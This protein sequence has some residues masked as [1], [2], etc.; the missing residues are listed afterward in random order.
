MKDYQPTI[1]DVLDLL[2]IAAHRVTW[3]SLGL[4]L[5]LKPTDLH[6]CPLC[7]LANEIMG[8]EYRSSYGE[9]ACALDIDLTLARVVADAADNVSVPGDPWGN[10]QRKKLRADL[11]RI[12]KAA[13]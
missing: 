8:T 3:R 6:V 13:R 7:A 1:Q 12:I 11:Q 9:A 5:D 2:P 10:E 4:D